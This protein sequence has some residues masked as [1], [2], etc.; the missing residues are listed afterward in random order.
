MK[1]NKSKKMVKI[2]LF[3]I[4]LLVLFFIVGGFIWKINGK[5]RELKKINNPNKMSDEVITPNGILLF[6]YEYNMSLEPRIIYKSLYNVAYKVLP[7]YYD[8]LKGENENQLRKYF[9]KNKESILCDLG[10][11]EEDDFVE[12]IKKLITLN[13]EKL[14]MKE[15]S[16]DT[17]SIK[18]TSQKSTMLLNIIY[19]S[20]DPILL[21]LTVMNST[22]NSRS[23]IIYKINK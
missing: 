1:K 9:I 13:G 23:P 21:N 2:K 4:I 10:T 11:N 19:E 6:F 15:Y 20:N 18:H 5:Y 12:L 14:V 17:N 7:Q 22:S 16:I 3:I 8:K